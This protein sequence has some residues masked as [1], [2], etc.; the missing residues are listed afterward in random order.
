MPVA[1]GHLRRRFAHRQRLQSF[2][3]HR[4]DG[5]AIGRFDLTGRA[6]N[7]DHFALGRAGFGVMGGQRGQRSAPRFLMHLG[8]FARHGGVTR[9]QNLGHIG[10]RVGQA[11]RRFVENHCGGH[12]LQLAQCFYSR[13]RFIGQESGKEEAIAGQARSC[14]AGSSAD[15]PGTLVT[16]R[17]SSR[18]AR[19]SR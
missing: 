10:Q 6:D 17:S 7:D 2:R 19:T 4:I 12:G 3:Q 5:I 16:G 18:Q 9:P 1:G 13:H 8:Q 14:N 15:A 11:L